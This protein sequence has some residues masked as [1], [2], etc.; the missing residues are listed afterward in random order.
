MPSGGDSH[1]IEDRVAGLLVLLYGQPLARIARLTS[2][3]ITCTPSQVRMLLGTTPLELPAPLDELARLLGSRRR[4]HAAAGRTDDYPWA[5]PNR[6]RG[7]IRSCLI[8][9][10]P[11]R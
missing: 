10:E 5:F 3:Q 4:G 7:D 8:P 9:A 1:A 6:W 11:W 2:D